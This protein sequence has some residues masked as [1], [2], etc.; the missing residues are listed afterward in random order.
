MLKLNPIFTENAILQ[1]N[2]PVR[3]FGEGS[4]NVTVTLGT[5]TVKA[6]SSNGKWLAELPPHPY[7]DVCTLTVSDSTDTVTFKNITFGDVYLLSGQSN[8]QFK[9]FEAIPDG[10]IVENPD[11]RLFST[12]RMEENEHFKPEDGWVSC[13]MD[14]APN[15]SAIGYFLAR[16]L[17]KASPR[18]IGLVSL[19]QGASVIQSWLSASSLSELD[20]ILPSDGLHWDHHNPEY[21]KWNGSSTLHDFAF[22]QIVPFSFAAVIWYQ[23]ES[24]ASENESKIYDILLKKLVNSW[25]SELCD[26]SLPFVIIQIADYVHRSDDIWRRIQTMQEK[27]AGELPYTYLVRCADI[28]ETDNIHPPTKH[29]L[30]RRVTDA[31][32]SI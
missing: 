16:D 8:M 29:L 28:C 21:S 31:L 23:G 25:R 19:Y 9:L 32:K 3:I 1:A 15:F 13:N 17:Y 27:A 2:K 12:Q 6:A 26:E 30:V 4:G 5:D 18:P 7:N 10:E 14:T 24:N 11:V 22:S 20:S